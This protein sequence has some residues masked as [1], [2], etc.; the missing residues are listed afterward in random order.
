MVYFGYKSI[1]RACDA[2]ERPDMH[3]VCIK[4]WRSE[5]QTQGGTLPS[6]STFH[7]DRPAAALLY[8]EFVYETSL[9]VGNCVVRRV[10]D[11]FSSIPPLPEEK[12]NVPLQF[13]EI[14]HE[15]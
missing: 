10:Q 15:G 5:P 1:V 8:C 13:F 4:R 3:S 11:I 6:A 14:A 9:S 7:F 2:S 12:K